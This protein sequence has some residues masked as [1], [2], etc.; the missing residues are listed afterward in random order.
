MKQNLRTKQQPKK[1]KL[2]RIAI[3]AIAAML[4]AGSFG[5]KWGIGQ[6]K[7][8]ELAGEIANLKEENEKLAKIAAGPDSARMA[9]FAA[10]ADTSMLRIAKIDTS[11]YRGCVKREQE[12]VLHCTKKYDDSY[13]CRKKMWPGKCLRK[14]EH[15]R[16]DT[17]WTGKWRSPEQRDSAMTEWTAAAISG[18]ALR[19]KHLNKQLSELD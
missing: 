14:V 19:I 6:H 4:L 10:R 12:P 16:Y 9:W 1:K 18:N 15:V 8:N 7:K 3:A 11:A 17:T 5:L 13:I 2:A